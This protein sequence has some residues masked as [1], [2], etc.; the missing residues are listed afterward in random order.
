MKK[1]IMIAAMALSLVINAS[2]QAGGSSAGAIGG[3][4]S[5]MVEGA[6]LVGVTAAVF[7]NASGSSKGP[8]NSPVPPAPPA[9]TCNAGDDLIQGVCFNYD[10]EIVTTV[11]GS[12]TTTSTTTIVVPVTSTYLPS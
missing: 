1:L 10:T 12:G 2:E 11:T 8:T 7:T 5:S 9:P 4:S 3:M 6:I